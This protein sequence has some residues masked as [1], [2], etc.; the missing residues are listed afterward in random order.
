MSNQNTATSKGLGFLGEDLFVEGTIHAKKKLVVGGTV[1]GS[2][3]G[4]QEIVIAV[5]GNVNGRIEGNTILVA[6]K[7]AGDLLAHKRL[8]VI[9][10]AT[11]QGEMQVPSGQLLIHEG[12]KL[13]AQC[14]TLFKELPQ[15]QTAS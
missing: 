13:E 9:P 6:G 8:E 3:S 11:I 15:K 7:V 4:D 2:V 14:K 5:T 1:N 10:S 12:A